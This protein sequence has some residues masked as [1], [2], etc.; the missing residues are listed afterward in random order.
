MIRWN[1]ATYQINPGVHSYLF[2]EDK[3]IDKKLYFSDDK[4]R[5]LTVFQKS[6]PD[7]LP[8]YG[9]DNQDNYDSYGKQV[10]SQNEQFSKNIVDNNL[11]ISL[12]REK[13]RTKIYTHCQICQNKIDFK[14]KRAVR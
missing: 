9:K 14:W 10:V 1:D 3:K 4:S 8:I 5:I 13:C 6:T 12:V 2:S 7:Y 11:V